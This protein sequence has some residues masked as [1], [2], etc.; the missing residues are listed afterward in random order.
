MIVGKAVMQSLSLNFVSSM[1]D[2]L[3]LHTSAIHLFLS[4]IAAMT[5]LAFLI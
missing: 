2:F 3:V 4:S 1:Y 5:V